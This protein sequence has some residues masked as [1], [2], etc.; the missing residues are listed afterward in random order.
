[1]WLH[2]KDRGYHLLSSLF[3][4]GLLHPMFSDTEVLM[5]E[6]RAES[7]SRQFTSNLLSKPGLKLQ[8]FVVC[9]SLRWISAW[10]KGVGAAAAML[11]GFL[12]LFVW[13]FFD[14]LLLCFSIFLFK[15]PAI[16]YARRLLCLVAWVGHLQNKSWIKVLIWRPDCNQNLIL[17]MSPF[18]F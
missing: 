2:G 17:C 8:V 10:V 11:H 7:S 5:G 4:L 6:G 12:V 13:I 18:F 9:V 1:M 3:P 16:Y 15:C 14:N